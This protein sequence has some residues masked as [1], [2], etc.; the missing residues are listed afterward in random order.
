MLL[1]GDRE[2]VPSEFASEQELE[3]LVLDN[4]ERIFGPW[5]LPLAKAKLRTEGGS[6]TIPDAYVVDLETRSWYL[7]EVELARHG[8]W[9]HIAPQVAKQLTASATA[10]SRQQLAELAFESFKKEPELL[11]NIGDLGIKSID[12]RQEIGR[13][14]ERQP[15]VA[16]PID[17]IKPDLE[18]WAETLK[19][20]VRL[21]EI[22]KFSEFGAP[23]NLIYRL[24]EEFAPTFAT[25]ADAPGPV[26]YGVTLSD[27]LEAEK[28]AVGQTLHFKYRPQGGER[29]FYEG[30]VTSQGQIA[31]LGQEYSPSFAALRCM[32][33][34]G[35]KRRTVNGWTAWRTSQ[36]KLLSEV[37]DELLAESD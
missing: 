36:G 24:P 27:L 6:G 11:A 26:H 8:V 23:S 9:R 12:L 22:Q 15:I 29:T 30:T 19:A 21:W 4:A 2:F 17:T 25:Q 1:F 18:Q 34:S 28:L 16:I 7:V 5:S 35:S 37:R 14:F 32:Q 10:Q 13:I 3:D 31:V 33:A 20:D